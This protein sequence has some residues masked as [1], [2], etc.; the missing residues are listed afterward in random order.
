MNRNPVVNSFPVP[1][2]LRMLAFLD[3]L[4]ASGDTNMLGAEQELG[5]FNLSKME[6]H[7]VLAYWRE[8]FAERHPQE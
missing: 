8:T 6:S 1:E 2:M 5:V 4:H 3:D 7:A